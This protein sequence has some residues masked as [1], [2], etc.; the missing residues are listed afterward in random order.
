MHT[1]PMLFSSIYTWYKMSAC[2]GDVETVHDLEHT[3]TWAELVALS[4]RRAS[5][6]GGFWWEDAKAVDTYVKTKSLRSD[7]VT[8]ESSVAKSL[9][10]DTV[11]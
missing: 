11:L 8:I 3:H 5:P 7:I 4:M 1:N 10:C 6:C 9:F 2:A